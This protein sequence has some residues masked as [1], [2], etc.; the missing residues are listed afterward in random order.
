MHAKVLRVLGPRPRQRIRRAGRQS[1]SDSVATSR[2]RGCHQC[3]EWRG[4]Q[5]CGLG[6]QDMTGELIMVLRKDCFAGHSDDDATTTQRR[7]ARCPHRLPVRIEA[8]RDDA[9]DAMTERRRRVR[10]P[11]RIESE[12]GTDND[13]ATTRRRRRDG[14]DATRRRRRWLAEASLPQ[15]LQPHC[16]PSCC[17]SRCSPSCTPKRPHNRWRPGAVAAAPRPAA[18]LRRPHNC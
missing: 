12:A 13:A 7:P 5:G 16:S 15:S 3:R 10:I 17:H 14:D 4:E 11:V 8:G 18:A 9:D 2:D 6:M 1:D